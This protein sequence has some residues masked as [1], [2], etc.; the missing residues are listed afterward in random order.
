M[1][2]NW[3]NIISTKRMVIDV[4]SISNRITFFEFIKSDYKYNLRFYAREM[5]MNRFVFIKRVRCC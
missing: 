2:I 5:Y 3:V 4:K 1:F